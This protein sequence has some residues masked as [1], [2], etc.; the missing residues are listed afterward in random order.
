WL[1]EE[2]L[3]MRSAWLAV[4][5]LLALRPESGAHL[6]PRPL[7][8]VSLNWKLAGQLVD[9]THNHGRDNRI[10]SEALGERRDLYVYL[11]PGY[12]PCKKFPL[13]V[14]LHGF[15]EDEESFLNDALRPLDRAMAEGK[16]PPA[17]VAAPDGS[18]HGLNC[19]ATSGTFFL[20][21]K[22]GNFDDFL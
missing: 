22:L 1:K 16:L 8:L 21:S 15:N 19:L 14:Y 11:P 2:Q 13:I 6:L 4:L 7:R 3:V 20:N 17:I 10:W 9:H 5:A 12:S 18:V